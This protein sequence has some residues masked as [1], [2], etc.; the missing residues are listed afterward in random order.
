MNQ[1]PATLRN[2]DPA[3]PGENWFF[4][5]KTSASL[6]RQKL[7]EAPAG[8]IIV[9]INWA[10]HTDTGENFDFGNNKP[11]SNLAQ[12]AS[13]AEMLG[14]ELI[15]FLPLTPL[16]F[17]PNGGVPHLL[18]RVP[19]S[20][21]DGMT[22][23]IMDN[24]EQIIKLIS[25]FDSR[26]YQA[27]RKFVTGLGRYFSETGIP[28]NVWGLEAGYLKN[29]RFVSYIEDRSSAF[30]Q[31]FSRYLAV[32]KEERKA[33]KAQENPE[34]E[35]APQEEGLTPREEKKLK[36]KFNHIISDLYRE[37][38]QEAL[39]G[40]YEGSLRV[41][42]LGGAAED[43]FRRLVGGDDWFVHSRS[44]MELTC[45]DVLTSSVLLSKTQPTVLERQL[46]EMVTT[47]LLPLKLSPTTYDPEEISAWA[48][49]SLFEIYERNIPG[50]E[51]NHCWKNFGLIDY[52]DKDY[53]WNFRIQPADDF[54]MNEQREQ[55]KSLYFFHG[56]NLDA[57]KLTHLLKVFMSGG[58]II[59]NRSR[60]GLSE[61][62]R[63]E[64]FFLENNL[65]IEKVSF[66]TTIH[67][68]KLG[69]GRFLVFEGEKLEELDPDKRL[70]FWHDLL[71]T[72]NLTKLEIKSEEGLEYSWRQ[73]GAHATELQFEEVRRLSVY[74]PTS[75]K[76]RML[77]EIPKNFALIKL[78][79]ETHV[80]SQSRPG[81][82]MLEFLPMGSITLD[83]GLFS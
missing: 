34:G 17:L 31:A 56:E 45:R 49:L 2:F 62:K 22:Y 27:Y 55:P 7:S 20:N 36:L 13:L 26:V 23:A 12:L 1:S 43:F 50:E 14:K 15:F 6:W 75:Y 83:F 82:M 35:E 9:P 76:K 51:N 79:D 19:A 18:A 63:L 38:A 30:V 67:N 70:I 77:L 46:S 28:C 44:I 52:L 68:I 71:A 3:F 54:V 57:L 53:R 10:F 25:F 73:R 64:A 41:G 78:L 5:W 81:S 32:A 40:H 11:E 33:Q 16:P 61:Q 4:Y 59:L 37:S 48:P 74:N 21:R 60:I 8:P 65:E 24:E 42:F 66:Y 29:R 72:F 39:A 69:E 80:Q 47:T 58:N